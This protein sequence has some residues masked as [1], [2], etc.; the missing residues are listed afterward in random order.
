LKPGDDALLELV[1]AAQPTR[2]LGALQAFLAEGR[3]AWSSSLA[4]TPEDK[5]NPGGCWSANA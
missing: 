4:V 3:F 5:A 2:V 1:R